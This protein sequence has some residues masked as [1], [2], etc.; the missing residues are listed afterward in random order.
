VHKIGKM[1]VE[2]SGTSGPRE[3]EGELVQLLM[4]AASLLCCIS[5]YNVTT[6][7]AVLNS[8]LDTGQPRDGPDLGDAFYLQWLVRLCVLLCALCAAYIGCCQNPDGYVGAH[9]AC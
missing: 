9:W 5:A 2:P 3:T 6:L 7:K 8:R 4:E 1:L